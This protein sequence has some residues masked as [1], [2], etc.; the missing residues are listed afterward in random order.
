M[1]NERPGNVAA[2]GAFLCAAELLCSRPPNDGFFMRG[3]MGGMKHRKLRI[4]WSI[5]C[6]ILCL[7][8]IVLWVISYGE[9]RT[10]ISYA[11]YDPNANVRWVEIQSYM[12]RTGTDVA[13]MRA[14]D[15]VPPA[16]LGGFEIRSNRTGQIVVIT[17][18]WFL[19]LSICAAAFVPWVRW[20]KFTLGT[21]LIA[22]S[23]VSVLLGLLVYAARQ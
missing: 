11:P 14:L 19:V 10:L 4:A 2:T 7:L 1:E 13:M 8:L 17:P 21:L 20:W 16:S 15:W 23:L 22:T 3:R 5:A 6:G 18:Y 12:G 9:P